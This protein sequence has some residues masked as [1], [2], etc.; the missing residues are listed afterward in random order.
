MNNHQCL[1]AGAAAQKHLAAIGPAVTGRTDATV[2]IGTFTCSG[3][4]LQA[5]LPS[6]DM[7]DSDLDAG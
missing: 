2:N 6:S 1:Q 7:Y 5:L 4:G 3:A